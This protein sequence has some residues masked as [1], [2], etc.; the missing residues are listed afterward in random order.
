MS[1]YRFLL[2]RR[3]VLLVLGAAAFVVVCSEL[4]NWQVHR[5]DDRRA[6]NRVVTANIDARPVPADRLLAPGT[7]VDPGREWRPVTARGRYDTGDQ[8]VVR[9]RHLDGEPGF[10]VLT[11][12]VT[13]RGPILLVNR[14]WVPTAGDPMRL[15]HP[16]AP[17]PGEVTVTGRVRQSEQGPP[18]QVRP[19]T[20]EI[21]YIDVP[22]LARSLPHP[23]YGAYV[24]LTAQHPTAPHHPRPVPPPDLSEGPHLAYAVQWVIFAVI[25]IGGLVF[26]AYDEAHGGALRDRM[27]SQRVPAQGTRRE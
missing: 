8:V 17:P 4:S 15:P 2:Q 25:A 14:G 5:L 3:W 19:A 20:G 16:P 10:Y 9:Y 13:D 27:R 18:D 6:E 7:P 12:L 1:R 22:R 24:E 23:V 21:R 11:P 26:L